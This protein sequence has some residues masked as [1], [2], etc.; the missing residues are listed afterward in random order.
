MPDLP[1]VQTELFNYASGTATPAHIAQETPNQAEGFKATITD[2]PD[3]AHMYKVAQ[4]GEYTSVTVDANGHAVSP[5]TTTRG[6]VKG[7]AGA[8]EADK[9]AQLFAAAAKDGVF[10]VGE[11]ESLRDYNTQSQSLP[12]GGVRINEN[13]RSGLAR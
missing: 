5:L 3:G 8:V 12:A 6:R 2:L 7:E 1:I 11:I 4:D 10:K 9:F 13:I